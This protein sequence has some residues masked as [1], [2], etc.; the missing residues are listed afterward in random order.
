MFDKVMPPF[1][2]HST[3]KIGSWVTVEHVRRYWPSVDDYVLGRYKLDTFRIIR[4]SQDTT[5]TG[6]YALLASVSDKGRSTV[7]LKSCLLTLASDPELV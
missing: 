2:L 5:G 3:V 1:L 7:W 6:L 4:I